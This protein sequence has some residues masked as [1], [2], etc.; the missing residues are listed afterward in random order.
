MQR[1]SKVNFVA[2]PDMLDIELAP[3]ETHMADELVAMWRASFEHGVG[4]VD[5]NP[6]AAQTEYFS[7][8]VL[9]QH[10]VTVALRGGRLLGFA[11]YTRE[12][13][14]QL[15]VRVG[16]LRQGLGSLLMDLMKQQSSGSLWLYTF[17]RNAHARRFYEKH[18]FAI[19]AEGFEPTW[20]LA[21]VK[22]EW[23]CD[24]AGEPPDTGS[25]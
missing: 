20:Q 9:P 19:I 18:G 17:A 8:Q 5:P 24:A 21:D 10:S 23:R 14:S 25:T 6:I 22:Y 4:V 3:F 12:S 16:H 11:A 13:V 2:T 7:T 1:M 15:H